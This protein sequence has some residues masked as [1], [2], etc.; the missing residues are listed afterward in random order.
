SGP[1]ALPLLV[2]IGISIVAGTV[3]NWL[4]PLLLTRHPLVLV[5]L[6]PRLRYLVL[7]S[8]RLPVVPFF[9][10]PLVRLVAIDVLSYLLGRWCGGAVLAWV[11][12][13]IGP[14]HRL[15]GAL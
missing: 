4:A 7:T 14:A 8:S 9:A 2:S 10:V 11:E 12:R 15:L 13:R 3:A 6:N 5:G 1:T